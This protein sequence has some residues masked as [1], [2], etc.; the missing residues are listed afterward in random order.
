MQTKLIAPSALW[1]ARFG[2]FLALGREQR[3]YFVR[4]GPADIFVSEQA[5]GGIKELALILLPKP[6]RA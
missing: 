5:T 6:T 4:N 2:L 1:S 3:L